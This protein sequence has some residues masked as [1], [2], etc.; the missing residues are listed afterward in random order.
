MK[1][2]IALICAAALLIGLLAV[3]VMAEG[4]KPLK[5]LIV[6]TTGVNDGNFN[7]DCYL[8]IQNFLK[9]HPDCTVP[10]FY[11]LQRRSRGF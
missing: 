6:S 8:G 9:N 4:G 1:K 3:P 11:T 10:Y 5:I 7:Q 2:W